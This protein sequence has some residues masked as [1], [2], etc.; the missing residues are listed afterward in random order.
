MIEKIE[1]IKKAMDAKAYLC[2]L[3]LALTLPDIC[4]QVAYPDMNRR[5]QSQARYIKW[6]DEYITQYDYPASYN[7]N[8]KFD[9]IK[10]WKLRC[11]ILHSGNTKGISS[12]IG[13]SLCI[14]ENWASGIFGPSSYTEVSINNNHPT[15][16]MTI[17]VSQQCFIMYSCA[18]GF[19]RSQEDKTKFNDHNL[20]IIDM[21]VKLDKK[22]YSS[23]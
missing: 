8:A 9:G 6:Y 15:Y 12:T 17:D 13:F 2:A 3:A 16:H 18:E 7:G 1:D 14:N 4:G 21:D 5:N 22:Y 10:C 19:Y 11:A 23:D 20:E